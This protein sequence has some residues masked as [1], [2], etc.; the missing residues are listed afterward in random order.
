MKPILILQQLGADRA[1]E[2]IGPHLRLQFQIELDADQVTR[3]S[4]EHEA[5][6]AG[7]AT[8][9]ATHQRLAHEH[10]T[11]GLRGMSRA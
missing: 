10:C 9:R 5:L 7:L 3:W 11:Q 8:E 1:S 4:L 2:A 6:R